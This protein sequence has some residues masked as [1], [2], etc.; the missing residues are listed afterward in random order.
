MGQAL[1]NILIFAGMALV[2]YMTRFTLI[3]ALGRDLPEGVV[4]WLRFIPLAVLSALITPAIFAPTGK[5]ELGLPVLALLGG[6]FIAWRTRN[7]FYT[8][9]AGLAIFWL[10]RLIIG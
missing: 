3:G 9:L 10:M 2:T 5:L 4:R 6:A 8:I 1:E 7:V